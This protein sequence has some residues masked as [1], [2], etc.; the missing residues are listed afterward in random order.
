M[1]FGKRPITKLV[2]T[3]LCLALLAWP[4]SI[5]TSAV[6]QDNIG[7]ALDARSASIGDLGQV[8]PGGTGYPQL[9]QGIQM[10]ILEIQNRFGVSAKMFLMKESGGPNAFALSTRHNARTE[11]L[12]QFG[13]PG[14]ASPDGVVVFGVDLMTSEFR[15]AFGSGYGIPAIIGHEYAH[16]MQFKNAIPLRGKWIELHADYMAGWFTAHRGRF[17]RIQNS[18]ESA[19]S[20][21]NKGD[22][23]FNS[24]THHGTP[25][26]RVGAFMAG[27]Q[28]NMQQNQPDARAAYASG[29]N[30][31]RDQGAR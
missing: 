11:I 17:D 29:I 25:A 20:F 9:D 19:I 8:L 3:V 27:F 7:C 6:S 10:D 30:Y 21:F 18:Q 12:Q 31:L 24:E 16:I 2:L 22:Y 26:E 28:L 4:V 23:A 5:P 15:S 1:R 13:I 14:A